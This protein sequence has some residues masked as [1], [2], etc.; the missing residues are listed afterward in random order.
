MNN[1]FLANLDRNKMA[2]TCL[3]FSKS[4]V[5]TVHV[6]IGNP[7]QNVQSKGRKL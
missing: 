7:I 5:V 4:Q 1:K 2:A 6:E 3:R